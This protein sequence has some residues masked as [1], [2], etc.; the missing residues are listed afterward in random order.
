MQHQ[1]L[2]CDRHA[3]V[4]RFTSILLDEK[5]KE[6]AQLAEVIDLSGNA[7]N[8]QSVVT[9]L[10]ELL[11]EATRVRVLRMQEMSLHCLDCLE[12]LRLASSLE[13]VDLSNNSIESLDGLMPVLQSNRSPTARTLHVDLRF[14][15]ISVPALEHFLRRLEQS[16]LRF[17]R[18]VTIDVSANGLPP[19]MQRK[20]NQ[21]LQNLHTGSTHQAKPT[22]GTEEEK[23]N[24]MLEKP[25]M[26][27]VDFSDIHERTLMPPDE[28]E[29]HLSNAN[30][31]LEITRVRQRNKSLEYTLTQQSQT[32]QQLRAQCEESDRRLS[33]QKGAFELRLNVLTRKLHETQENLSTESSRFKAQREEAKKKRIELTKRVH[34]L[35]AQNE[36]AEGDKQNA[37]QT[38]R[39]ELENKMSDLKRSKLKLEEELVNFQ[40]RE[41]ELKEKLHEANA[42]AA[43]LRASVVEKSKSAQAKDE[44]LEAASL[45]QRQLTVECDKL[46]HKLKQQTLLNQKREAQARQLESEI[47]SRTTELELSRQKA[48]QLEQELDQSRL[49]A[50][51]QRHQLEARLAEQLEDAQRSA[52]RARKLQLECS[53]LRAKVHEAVR[54]LTGGSSTVPRDRSPSPAVTPQKPK[55]PRLQVPKVRQRLKVSAGSAQS[56]STSVLDDSDDSLDATKYSIGSDTGSSIEIIV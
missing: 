43:G 47:E 48:K 14:N 9:A 49:S 23:Q 22:V 53:N 35:E 33:T 20:L 5:R 30:L 55:E 19:P 2:L 7:A 38:V 34:E 36:S 31:R 17:S 37:V 56:V 4:E 46:K 45:K 13:S 29:T 8:S 51:K 12:G 3:S 6:T 10:G 42:V 15:A 54:T 52:R 41:T 40:H 24:S 32:E 44:E 11:R 28:L 18:F 25:K 26:S 39:I 21:T 1:L 16:T 27:K 50:R